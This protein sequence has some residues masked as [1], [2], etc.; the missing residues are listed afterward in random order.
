MKVDERN[1]TEKIELNFSQNMGNVEVTSMSAETG[2]AE[3]KVTGY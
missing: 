2:N 3:T 1:K